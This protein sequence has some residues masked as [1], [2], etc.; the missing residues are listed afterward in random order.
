MSAWATTAARVYMAAFLY[1]AIRLEHRR[2]AHHHPRVDLGIDPVRIRRLVKLGFPAASQVALEVGVFAAATAL[3]C[4][5]M[6]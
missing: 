5:P 2:R 3:A 6:R 4:A 1:L